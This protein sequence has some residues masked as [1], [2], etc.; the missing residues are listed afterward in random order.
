MC[1]GVIMKVPLGGGRCVQGLVH[2]WL[3]G[4]QAWVRLRQ[5]DAAAD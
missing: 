5:A 3:V 4:R 2:F 1:P